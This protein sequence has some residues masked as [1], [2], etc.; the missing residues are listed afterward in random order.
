MDHVEFLDVL[1]ACQ[2]LNSCLHAQLYKI[3]DRY[4]MILMLR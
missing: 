4:F 1:R 3:Y 2:S